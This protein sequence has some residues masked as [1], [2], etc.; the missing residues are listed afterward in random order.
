MLSSCAQAM[1]LVG[2]IFTLTLVGCVT[3][4]VGPLNPNVSAA[5]AADA[6]VDLAI[7]YLQN[8]EYDL[9]INR[10]EKA[11][12][13]DPRHV[14]AHA[15]LGLVFQRQQEWTAAEAQFRKALSI[16]PAN[17]RART[18][19]GAF[20]Y[21][22]GRLE[23]ALREFEFAARDLKYDA[24]ASVFQNIGL[25]QRRLDRPA[26]AI[27]AYERAA[28]LRRGDPVAALALSELYLAAGDTTRAY[29]HYMQFWDQVRAGQAEHTAAT[30]AT[31][32][33][34]ARR[35]EDRNTEAS[36]ML[37]LRNRF[38]DSPEYQRLAEEP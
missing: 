4:P 10:L 14:Q 24:R 36:L 33:T 12:E 37:L 19:H 25:I 20:L 18:F 5:R 35:V 34:I 13:I 11:L 16:D 29:R 32:V 28:V 1:R 2:L 9:A 17:T 38:G 26:Q 15:V 23:E 8:G 21:Q 3:E 6:Y 7:A 31:G 27:E 22:Q 30:L